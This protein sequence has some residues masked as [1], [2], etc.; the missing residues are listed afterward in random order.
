M[1][2]SK[3]CSTTACCWTYRHELIGLV[4]LAIATFLTIV[5]FNGLGIAAM[6]LVAAVLCSYRHVCC[7]IAHS[8]GQCHSVDDEMAKNMLL[9]AEKQPVKKAARKVKKA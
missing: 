9:G 5:T 2:N 7:H 4:L 1:K 3:Y 6:F 8:D